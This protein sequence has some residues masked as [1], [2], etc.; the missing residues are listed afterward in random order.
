MTILFAY[1]GADNADA[2]IV[3]AGSLL[4]RQNGSSVVVSVAIRLER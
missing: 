2:A 4:T 1:D 3:A